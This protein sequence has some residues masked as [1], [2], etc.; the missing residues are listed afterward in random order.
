MRHEVKREH[1]PPT[2]QAPSGLRPTAGTVIGSTVV[3]TLEVMCSQTSTA[4]PTLTVKRTDDGL[5]FGPDV[6]SYLL[7]AHSAAWEQILLQVLLFAFLKK[8]VWIVNHEAIREYSMGSELPCAVQCTINKCPTWIGFSPA[9]SEDLL[10]D[11]S[12]SWDFE[13]GYLFLTLDRSQNLESIKTLAS[14]WDCPNPP[15][16]AEVMFRQADGYLVYW[17]H[18]SCGERV[19]IEALR[20]AALH[21]GWLFCERDNGWLQE[22]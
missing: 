21:V 16:D 14:T 20:E 11:V 3:S 10:K 2:S 22:V 9:C 17:Y 7:A 18:P 19:A 8:P 13:L 5:E 15:K 1:Q 6:G 4:R 12:E